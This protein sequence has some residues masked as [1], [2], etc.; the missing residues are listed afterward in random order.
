[1]IKVSGY[2]KVENLD[3]RAHRGLTLLVTGEILS[4]T[5][6]PRELSLREYIGQIHPQIQGLPT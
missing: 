4:P 2:P 1:M 3:P 5:E 6:D